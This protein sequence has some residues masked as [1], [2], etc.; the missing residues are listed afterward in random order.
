MEAD[1]PSD[2]PCIHP[3]LY[4]HLYIKEKNKKYQKPTWKRASKQASSTCKLPNSS[5][6][7]GC[8]RQGCHSEVF[9]QIW[10]QDVWTTKVVWKLFISIF[11]IEITEEGLMQNLRNVC[12]TVSHFQIME[13]F[14]T[15]N[16]YTWFERVN[17]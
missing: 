1:L 15:Q 17:F 5:V 12:S 16:L 10:R 8:Y 9:L 6:L 4:M 3:F 2:F 14:H 13:I 11:Y 7:R